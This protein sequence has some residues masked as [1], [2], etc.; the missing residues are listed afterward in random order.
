MNPASGDAHATSLQVTVVTLFPQFFA[1]FLEEGVVARGLQQGLLGFRTV[2]LRDFAPLPRRAVDDRPIGGGDGMVLCPK[3]TA[4][5]IESCLTPQSTVVHLTPKGQVFNQSMA[6]KLSQ[7][8]ELIFLCGRYAGFDDR[9]VQKYAHIELS[10]GDF[11]L[12]GGEPAALVV[13]DAVFRLVPGVLGNKVS[14]G[15]D[16]FSEGLLEAPAYTQ[17]VDWEGRLVPAVYLSGNHK[18]VAA[19]R[20]KEQLRVTALNRPDLIM[21]VWENLT[22]SER[23]FVQRIWKHGKI[24]RG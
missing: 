23:T 10:V 15:A 4:A 9:V 6:E 1:P 5:A 17:P 16:S 13:M 14:A 3:V 11:V 20:R 12:S 19:F 22:A 7:K 8:K 2:S 21:L 18:N 24:F